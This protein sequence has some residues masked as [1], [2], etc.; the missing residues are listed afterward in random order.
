MKLRERARP[1]REHPLADVP[2]GAFQGAGVCERTIRSSVLDERPVEPRE[3]VV[4]DHPPLRRIDLA[5]VFMSISS[6]R[7]REK[8]NFTGQTV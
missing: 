5:G 1:L 4:D 8:K 7:I 2:H 3:D 6:L